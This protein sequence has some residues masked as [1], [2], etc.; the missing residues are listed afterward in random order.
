MANG[1]PGGHVEGAA[2]GSPPATDAANS[3]LR[4]AVAMVRRNASQGRCGLAVEASPFRHFGQNRRGDDRTDS[5]NG[6]EP[7]GLVRQ[8]DIGGDELGD[9]LIAWF[10]WLCQQPAKRPRLAL[11]E[12]ISMMFGPV[13]FHGQGVDALAAALGP[14]GQPLWLRRRGRR[15]ARVKG[16]AV[17]REH[18]GIHRIGLGPPALGAGAV[19]APPRCHHA[20]GNVGC[21]QPAHDRLLIT[22]GGLADDVNLRQRTH[23]FKQLGMAF[24]MVGQVVKTASEVKRQRELGHIE[25]SVEDRVVV[26]THPYRIRATIINGCRA[27]AT[28]RVQDHGHTRNELCNASRPSGC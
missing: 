25:A 16:A 9:G 24:D 13:G 18:G 26:R 21:L 10:D 14:I 7:A 1:A 23:P 11:T 15:D 2:D 27:Q 5:G 6:I 8:H 28:V 22:A 19:A 12:R 4:A 20:D 17:W 3:V